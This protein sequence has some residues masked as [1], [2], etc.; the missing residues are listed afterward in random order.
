MK[1][2]VSSSRFRSSICGAGTFGAILLRRCA[3]WRWLAGTLAGV[4]LERAILWD[5]LSVSGAL[6][7]RDINAQAWFES[8]SNGS[9]E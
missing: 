9:T 7:T 6:P 5:R 3:G 4:K 1:R 2:S 8:L